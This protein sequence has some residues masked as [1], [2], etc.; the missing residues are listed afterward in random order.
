MSNYNTSAIIESSLENVNSLRDHLEKIST[1]RQNIQST[2]EEVRQVPEHFDKLGIKL[3]QTSDEFIFKNY[4]L[5]K[6]QIIFF[7]EKI[8]DLNNRIAQIDEIDFRKRFE[9]ANEDFY[10]TLNRNVTEKIDLFNTTRTEFEESHSEF[11]NTISLNV[12]DKVE[13]FD[14]TRLK[15]EE[16]HADFL[17]KVDLN[18]EQK[19]NLFD[20][21]RL[22]F[23]QSYEDFL[24]KIDHNIAEKI[25]QFE[26]TNANLVR[27]HESLRSEVERLQKI[28]LEEHFNKH[29]KRL[30][31][32]FGG[33][34]NVNSSLLNISN[35]TMLF[36]EKLSG[37]DQKLQSM[38]NRLSEQERNFLAELKTLKD[39]HSV[40]LKKQNSNFTILAVL[41][42][43]AILVSAAMKFI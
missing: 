25:N 12:K 8:I 21:A 32:I 7:Q 10:S 30:S 42:S 23:E 28:N 26:E 36:Q 27:V 37:V 1:L 9:N 11:L 16:S 13:L 6:E 14:T 38:E 29:D 19:I 2:L 39:N 17:N 35:Q 24:N 5:L 41:I 22:R 40:A 43:I 34:N 31:D 20:S 15:L 3:S 18:V 4:E 33:I